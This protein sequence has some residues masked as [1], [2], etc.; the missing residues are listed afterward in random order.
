LLVA[1]WIQLYIGANLEAKHID[2]YNILPPTT[3]NSGRRE[4]CKEKKH[5]Q[6]TE[7][8]IVLKEQK[9]SCSSN[10]DFEETDTGANSKCSSRDHIE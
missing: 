10:K 3:S 1:T 5:H 7:Q 2:E 9:N 8:L 6:P 4:I